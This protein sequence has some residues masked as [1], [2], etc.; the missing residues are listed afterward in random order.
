M[1]KRWQQYIYKGWEI[2]ASEE[3]KGW[4]LQP[5]FDNDENSEKWEEFYNNEM[6][7]F[8]T[9]KEA[10]AWVG[11]DEAKELKDKYNK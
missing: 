3:I 8:S 2:R 10:K 11:T 5:V 6:I 4:D 9:L 1:A 7:T